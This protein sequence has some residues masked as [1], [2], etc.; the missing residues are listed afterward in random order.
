MSIANGVMGTNP[1]VETQSDMRHFEKP[2]GQRIFKSVARQG[3]VVILAFGTAG[4]QRCLTQ[5]KCKSAREALVIANQWSNFAL[6]NGL[7]EFAV[8]N[9]LPGIVTNVEPNAGARVR[10]DDNRDVFIHTQNVAKLGMKQGMRVLIRKVGKTKGKIEKFMFNSPWQAIEVE[11]FPKPSRQSNPKPKALPVS[12]KSKIKKQ[13]GKRLLGI[14]KEN[15]QKQ[16]FQIGDLVLG[17]HG[18]I[19]RINKIEKAPDMNY[20]HCD[21]VLDKQLNFAKPQPTD[22]FAAQFCKA[23][24]K[25][26]LQ[27]LAGSGLL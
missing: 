5:I 22:I 19:Y 23:L 14:D 11:K 1:K 10:T 17:Y 26:I 25:D 6:L 27:L 3:N 13:L 20:C 15:P 16:Q 2:S 9:F 21:L 18:G 12:A 4:H 8:N 24:P 7:I